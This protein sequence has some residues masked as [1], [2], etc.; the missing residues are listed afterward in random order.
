MGCTGAY[1]EVNDTVIRSV[2]LEDIVFTFFLHPRTPED[3]MLAHGDGDEEGNKT[4][5]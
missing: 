1:E 5:W 4:V 2:R 3:E